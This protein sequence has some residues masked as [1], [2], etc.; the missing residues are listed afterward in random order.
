M[1]AG[2]STGGKVAGRP[3]GRKYVETRRRTRKLAPGVVGLCLVMIL[4]TFTFLIASPAVAATQVGTGRAS[5]YQ[6][7]GWSSLLPELSA[8]SPA[9]QPQ[10]LHRP[11][12]A[13][14]DVEPLYERD[15]HLAGKPE[16]Q[17]HE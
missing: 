6:V 4:G 7:P 13:H 5:L 17:Q 14:A 3:I 12:H 10:S 16:L 2:S 15:D 11:S 1:S 8:A 9:V